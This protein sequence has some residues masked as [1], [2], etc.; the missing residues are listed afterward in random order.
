[1]YQPVLVE[2]S[3]AVGGWH[4][5]QEAREP[6]WPL[7]RP[8]FWGDVS[9]L[10]SLPLLSGS[11]AVSPH[12]Y[13]LEV[14]AP[15]PLHLWQGSYPFTLLFLVA[16]FAVHHWCVQVESLQLA[17]SF[18]PWEVDSIDAMEDSDVRPC[19]AL[20]VPEVESPGVCIACCHLGSKK[21]VF[22]QL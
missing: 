13:C 19:S 14:S 4:R 17:R 11:G 8:S 20:T 15:F 12:S 22:R 21:S 7:S 2:R 10:S 9:P 18:L 16:S 6:P 1:M 3:R 5:L